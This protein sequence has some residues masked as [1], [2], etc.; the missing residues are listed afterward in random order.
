[1]KSYLEVVWFL[2]FVSISNRQRGGALSDYAYMY[3]YQQGFNK[4]D[5]CILHK[6]FKDSRYDFVIHI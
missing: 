2:I 5:I 6:G 1:M 4:F 3:P